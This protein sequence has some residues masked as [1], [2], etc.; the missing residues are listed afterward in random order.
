MIGKLLMFIIG[1]LVGTFFGSVVLERLV[2]LI[3]TGLTG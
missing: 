2:K 1:F 3:L